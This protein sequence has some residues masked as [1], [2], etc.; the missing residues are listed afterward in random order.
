MM[1][2]NLVGYALNALDPDTQREVEAYLG[3][4]PDARRRLELLRRSLEPLAADRVECEPPAALVVQTLS[5]VAEYCCRDLPRAPVAPHVRAPV[6]SRP[7]WRR[8][9]VLVAATLLLTALGVGIPYLSHIHAQRGIAECQDNLRVFYNALKTYGDQHDNK[10]PNVAALEPPRNVAGLVAPILMAA[11]T[12]PADA[13]VGCPGNSKPKTCPLTLHDLQT[14]DAEAFNKHAQDLICC[15]A[16]SL[17]Y[18]DQAGGYHGPAFEPEQPNHLLPI[19]ADRPPR[20]PAA[21]NS[22]NHGGDGQNVLFLDGHVRF[23]PTRTVGLNGD[24]IYL[25]RDG[26]QAA[27]LDCT[28]TVLGSSASSP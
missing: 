5:R 10:L 14:L 7:L 22:A 4:N 17:G 23:C 9:D 11:G 2:D 27:G 21:G 3:T 18:R 24:D 16:Y 25:N 1:D 26:R 12:L 15:Y 13:N 6:A 28:D 20:D 19:M 8:V